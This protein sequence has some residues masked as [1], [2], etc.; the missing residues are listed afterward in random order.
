MKSRTSRSFWQLYEALPASVQAQS[1]Q[2]YA[3][4]TANPDHTSLNFKK[5]N[6]P[7]ERWSVRLGGEYRAVCQR[8]GAEVTWFWIGTRQSFGKD[9]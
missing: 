4:F 5:L 1:R 6:G 3:L 8:D 9:F 7:G 2:A